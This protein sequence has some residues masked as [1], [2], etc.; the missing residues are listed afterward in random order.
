MRRGL[1]GP[2]GCGAH[3]DPERILVQFVASDRGLTIVSRWP[4]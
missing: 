3:I 4:T 2:K 1:D